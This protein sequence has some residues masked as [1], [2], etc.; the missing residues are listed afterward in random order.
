MIKTKY[1]QHYFNFQIKLNLKKNSKNSTG[2]SKL[3]MLPHYKTT[4]EHKDQYGRTAFHFSVFY[5]SCFDKVRL[6]FWHG[7]KKLQADA[8]GNLA[9]HFAAEDWRQECTATIDLLVE[10]GFDGY[11]DF[12]RKD[13]RT[14]LMYTC[15]VCVL[16]LFLKCV[17]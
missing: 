9:L 1:Y 8:Q 4:L 13:G 15:N 2:T 17:C 6:L 10:K 12:P 7:C 11:V 3:L 5:P 14:P 16:K